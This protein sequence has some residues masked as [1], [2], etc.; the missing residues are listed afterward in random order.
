MSQRWR[1]VMV[2]GSLAPRQTGNG[3][4]SIEFRQGP[5][6]QLSASESSN[7]STTTHEWGGDSFTFIKRKYFTTQVKDLSE[8]VHSLRLESHKGLCSY[9]ESEHNSDKDPNLP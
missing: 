6:R 4:F 3:T 9:T 8:T 2:D 7:K 5:R 1:R